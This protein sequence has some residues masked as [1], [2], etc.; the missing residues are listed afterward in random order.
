METEQ[1]KAERF[2]NGLVSESELKAVEVFEYCANKLADGVHIEP[3]I[4][5]DMIAEISFLMDSD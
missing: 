1:E 4:K 2:S 3:E 5:K